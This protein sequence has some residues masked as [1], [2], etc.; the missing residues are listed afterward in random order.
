ML[1]RLKI[2]KEEYLSIL[3]NRGKSISS[4]ISLDKLLQKVKYLKKKDLKHLATIRNITID[5]DD[6]ADN[7]IS[8]L[9]KDI[10]KKKQVKVID[11]IYRYHQKKKQ[12]K[13]IGDMYR[14]HHKKKQPKVTGDIYRYH[15]KKKLTNLKQEMYRTIHKKQQQ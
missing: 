3:R 6:L 1:T 7:I 8:A 5:D 13:V 15:H 9:L 10:H 2:T 11:D 12:A 4:S 14:Y